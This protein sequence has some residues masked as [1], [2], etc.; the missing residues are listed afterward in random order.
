MLTAK[1]G[2]LSKAHYRKELAAWIFEDHPVYGPSYEQ[3][4]TAK[5][6]NVWAM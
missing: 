5:A 2:S 6:K 3:A 1:G 4:R